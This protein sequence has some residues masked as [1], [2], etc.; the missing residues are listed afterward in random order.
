MPTITEMFQ[1][2]LM[3]LFAEDAEFE[4]DGKSKLRVTQRLPA[5]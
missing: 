4:D 2:H 1:P 5:A 3:G